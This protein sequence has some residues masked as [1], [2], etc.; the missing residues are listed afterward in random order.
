MLSAVPSRNSTDLSPLEYERLGDQDLKRP[1]YSCAANLLRLV[2]VP[3]N[4]PGTP[5]ELPCLSH[6]QCRGIGRKAKVVV[7]ESR[8]RVA[9]EEIHRANPLEPGDI[10]HSNPLFRPPVHAISPYLP[11]DDGIAAPEEGDPS[12][13]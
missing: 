4:H 10:G 8:R 3:A 13:V 12:P 11:V 6:R 5:E 1:Q 7:N 2:Q 9:H